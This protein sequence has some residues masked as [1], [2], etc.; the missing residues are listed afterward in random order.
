MCKE[1]KWHMVVVGM[2][3]GLANLLGT[4]NEGHSMYPYPFDWNNPLLTAFSWVALAFCQ[5]WLY[6]KW[7][8]L[9]D[10]F[11]NWIK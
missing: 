2:V 11:K 5:A 4:W 8:A 7:C 1:D 3:Y 9:I 10:Y 6:S